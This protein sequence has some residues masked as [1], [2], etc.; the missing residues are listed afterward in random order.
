[1]HFDSVCLMGIGIVTPF[2]VFAPYPNGPTFFRTR[3]YSKGFYSIVFASNL[4]HSSFITHTGVA[5]F[6]RD[7]P[8]PFY[9]SK[10]LIGS[11]NV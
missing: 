5:P 8:K 2:K 10:F 11:S 6:L 4:F 3:Q 1:M 7:I 9:G